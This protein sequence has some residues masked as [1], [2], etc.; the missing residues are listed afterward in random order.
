MIARL[1]SL[2]RN[3]AEMSVWVA[4]PLLEKPS[5]PLNISQE[6]LRSVL[7]GK[8]CNVFGGQKEL[9]FK[10]G[11][12]EKMDY[13]SDE[14]KLIFNFI[15]H[16]G[17]VSEYIKLRNVSEMKNTAQF[18]A[19]LR[20]SP[21]HG[22]LSNEELCNYFSLNDVFSY[23]DFTLPFHFLC[24]YTYRNVMSKNCKL[25]HVTYSFGI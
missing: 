2:T 24:F 19:P 12:L 1:G 7:Y 15:H 25:L 13:S 5:G 17:T 10:S 21:L 6:V 20:A 16:Y 9:T 18:K 14:G 23:K 3:L 8:W 11:V 22:D 4:P